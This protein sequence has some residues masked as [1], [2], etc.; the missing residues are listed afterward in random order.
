S[1]ALLT[2]LSE[3]ADTKKE[4][5]SEKLNTMIAARRTGFTDRSFLPFNGLSRAR[6]RCFSLDSG[7]APIFSESLPYRQRSSVGGNTGILIGTPALGG[8]FLDP[9]ATRN[10]DFFG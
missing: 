5:A 3:H 9:S 7:P 10:V 1:D 8:G 4:S 6:R 2:L